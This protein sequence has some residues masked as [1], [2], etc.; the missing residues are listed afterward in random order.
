MGV[1]RLAATIIFILSVPVALVTTTIRFVANEPRVY[2][3]AIDQF[4]GVA[5]TGIDRAQLLQASAE[6]R[7]YFKNDQETLTIH[8]QEDGQDALLFN[9]R[10]TAHMKD[11]KSLLRGMDKAQ[12]FSVIYALSYV[13]IVVLWAREITPRALAMRLIGGSALC[14]AVLGV[15]GGFALT[16]F[17]SAWLDFHKIAFSNDFY[18]LNPATDHLIQMF[19]P[20]FWENIVFLVGLLIVAECALLI[21]GSFIYLGASRHQAAQRLTAR[22]VQTNVA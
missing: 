11:V 8:V 14:L 7:D 22:Y 12:E 1:F 3:Y 17:N 9:A 5:V 4:N 19:P 21:I 6:I 16:G 15:V 10:E 13:A 2:Q 18:L 20:A